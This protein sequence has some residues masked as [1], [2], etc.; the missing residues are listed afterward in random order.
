MEKY[1]VFKIRLLWDKMDKLFHLKDSQ[2]RGLNYIPISNSVHLGEDYK[3]HLTFKSK[4]NNDLNNDF[5]RVLPNI[6]LQNNDDTYVIPH[7]HAAY[8]GNL[9][10]LSN[11]EQELDIKI[12]RIDYGNLKDGTSYYWRYIYPIKF[13]RWFLQIESSIYID[14]DGTHVGM[15]YL[16]TIL[17]NSDM[18]IFLTKEKTIVIWSSS[19]EAR[20]IQKKCTKEFLLLRQ[21]LV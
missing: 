21:L 5:G 8:D 14:E 11:E 16:K 6:E 10:I 13:S 1:Q 3:L 4:Y 12:N 2:V 20:L 19:L 15:S 17:G 9:M 18:H 7:G